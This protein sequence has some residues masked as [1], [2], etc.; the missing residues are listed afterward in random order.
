V[1]LGCCSVL[2]MHARVRTRD[3][4]GVLSSVCFGTWLDLLVVRRSGLYSCF[5]CALSLPPVDIPVGLVDVILLEA[6][7][8]T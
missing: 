7:Y 5:F 8:I 2:M 4:P 1:F 3:F 6:Q